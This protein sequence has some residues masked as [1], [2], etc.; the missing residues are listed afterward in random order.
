MEELLRVATLL[1]GFTRPWFIAGGWAIDLYLGRLTRTHKDIEIAILRDDQHAIRRHLRGWEFRKV[2]RG[3]LEPWHEGEWL[4]MP[5]HE[6]HA[7]RE[8][9]DPS[10]LE[11]LLDESSADQ[12][13]F[14]RHPEITR[15]LSAIGMRSDGGVPFHSAEIVMLY[16]AT[17]SQISN[18][19]QADFE[20]ARESLDDERRQW[21]RHAIERCR[22][23][24]PWL[25]DR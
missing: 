19:D 21:L 22:P 15:P 23:G 5:V 4:G 11:I 24:H 14:R 20:I 3:R 10:A 17:S 16:K 6:I 7:H 13:T 1:A 18:H 8:N 9:G 2:L 12:W 25:V